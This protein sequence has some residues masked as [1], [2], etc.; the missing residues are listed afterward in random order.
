MAAAPVLAIVPTVLTSTHYSALGQVAVTGYVTGT[1]S[2]TAVEVS[3]NGATGRRSWL[4]PRWPF[5]TTW[6]YPWQPPAGAPDGIRVTARAQAK[7]SNGPSVPPVEARLTVD[8]VA[9]AGVVMALTADGT[10]VQ[11]G[12]ASCGPAFR[13]CGSLGEPATTVAALQITPSAG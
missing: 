9:P 4:D 1:A 5:T 8:V 11:P 13:S 10:P 7:V 3:I 6:S 12:E 2:V